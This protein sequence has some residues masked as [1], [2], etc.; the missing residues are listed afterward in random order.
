MDVQKIYGTLHITCDSTTGSFTVA[1]TPYR[2]R[3][4][5]LP[6]R[7]FATL[8]ELKGFLRAVKIG[9]EHIRDLE[10]ALAGRFRF[11]AV[12]LPP[13]EIQTHGLGK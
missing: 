13:E 9:D 12:G 5:V 8:D 11:R 7:Q 1:F 2:E 4:G 6:S 10:D 3:G